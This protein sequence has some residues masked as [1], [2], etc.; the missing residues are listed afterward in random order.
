MP[1]SPFKIGDNLLDCRGS[2]EDA[3]DGLQHLGV[4]SS[5]AAKHQD[6]SEGNLFGRSIT[7][8]ECMDTEELVEWLSND[9]ECGIRI[10]ALSTVPAGV[11]SLSMAV[12]LMPA[13][14]FSAVVAPGPAG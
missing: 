3:D 5:P 12:F 9:L 11:N 2:W 10:P 8:Q 6:E 7:L 14:T 4:V 13:E 1:H